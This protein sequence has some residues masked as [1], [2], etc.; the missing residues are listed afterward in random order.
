MLYTDRLSLSQH[1]TDASARDFISQHF[2]WFV[3]TWDNYPFPIQR[4]DA[5]RYF[6]L[7]HYGGIYL[8]LDTLCNRTIPLH[9]I[10]ADAAT[11][12][13][14]FKSTKPTGV[15]NDL[16]ISSPRHPL[17]TAAISKL[18]AYNEVTRLWARWQPYCAI[19]ISAGPM[20]LTMAIKN[21]LLEQPT[22]PSLTVQV[23]NATE[24]LPYMTDLESCSW[25]QGDAKALMW[26]G[27]RPWI[28]F[29]LGALG[30]AVGLHLINRLLMMTGRC[31]GNLPSVAENLKVTKLT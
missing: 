17:F 5:I 20:F 15:S 3:D 16:M 1:W 4:A 18:L 27:D 19:M 11:H 26:I 13:A 30:L 29:A 10:E 2:P 8:D 31:C 23:I 7:Y 28:W 9:Q 6:I 25:H 21:Y 24:L 14:V 22:L 12:H